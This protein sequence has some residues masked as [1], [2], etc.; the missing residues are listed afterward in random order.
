MVVHDK[1]K[2][3]WEKRRNKAQKIEDL[4]DR[5][6]AGADLLDLGTGSGF[7]AQYF[8]EAGANVSAADADGY[9][10]EASAPYFAIDGAELPFAAA[11]VDVVIFNHVIEHVGERAEQDAIL[12]EIA[13]V[14]RPGGVLYL[15]V[16][17]TWALIEAHYKLPVLGALPQPLADW[18]VRTI[19]RQ[20][21]YDC[22]PFTHGQLAAL[23]GKHF[24][25]VRDRSLDAYRWVMER[26][27]PALLRPFRVLR[28]P[29]VLLPS[30]IMLA[31]RPNPP[32]D[33]H[34]AP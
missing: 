3:T 18:L 7:L 15:G 32:G 12:A 11:S 21:R 23:V 5:P 16:P 26:E 27:A 19:R 34:S 14:L 10:Y 24:G 30:F 29:R 6:V 13:R 28:P 31:T 1:T 8:V 22:R 17:N 33:E 9:R 25:T 20:P 4:L 2:N